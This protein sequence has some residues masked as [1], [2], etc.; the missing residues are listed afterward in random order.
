MVINLL[1]NMTDRDRNDL[2]FAILNLKKIV[3]LAL[4]HFGLTTEG[5]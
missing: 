2:I 4:D 1:D 3:K 5:F